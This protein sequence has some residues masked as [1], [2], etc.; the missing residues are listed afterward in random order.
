VAIVLAITLIWLGRLTRRRL[1]VSEIRRKYAKKRV[2]ITAEHLNSGSHSLTLWSIQDSQG[3]PLSSSF[4]T[5]EDAEQYAIIN[6][7]N[8]IQ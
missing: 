3:N 2:W 5:W 6:G 4:F 7:Y 1:K 8:I